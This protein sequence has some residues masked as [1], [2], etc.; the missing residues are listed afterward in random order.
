[1]I[2]NQTHRSVALDLQPTARGWP[3]VTPW[4]VFHSDTTASS[5]AFLTC[6]VIGILST[7]LQRTQP[8]DYQ[9]INNCPLSLSLSPPALYAQ[10]MEK[11]QKEGGWCK[12]STCLQRRSGFLCFPVS[13]KTKSPLHPFCFVCFRYGSITLVI[14]CFDSRCCWTNSVLLQC[15]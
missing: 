8:G 9:D 12:K 11:E 6:K 3:S 7:M 10:K 14:H 13:P 2:Q 15:K 5:K 4:L 1:M